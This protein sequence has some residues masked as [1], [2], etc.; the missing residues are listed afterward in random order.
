[1]TCSQAS[2][3]SNAC[4]GV[5]S[6]RGDVA[7]LELAGA[8][9]GLYGQAEFYHYIVDQNLAAG[10]KYAPTLDFNGGYAELSYSIGGTRHYIPATGAYSGV[11]TDRPLSFGGGGWGALEIAARYSGIDLNSHSPGYGNPLGATG[12][13][14]GGFQQTWSIG[15]NYYPN[16]NM[17]FMLDFLHVNV[18]NRLYP[19]YVVGG[20]TGDLTVNGGV[21][22][23]AIAARTQINF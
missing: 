7:G 11:I 19:D 14:E 22:F 13:V 17:R 8:L 21:T 2:S 1:M 23:N 6:S 10:E 3:A 9:G 12:G 16:D 5:N 18:S 20:H 4:K 15:L